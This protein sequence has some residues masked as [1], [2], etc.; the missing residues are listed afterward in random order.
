MRKIFKRN[1]GE[2]GEHKLGCLQVKK[3]P[4]L[5]LIYFVCVQY[6]HMYMFQGIH[7]SCAFLCANAHIHMCT[8][9]WRSEVNVLSLAT[10]YCETGTL[11]GP[12][13][14]W[15][16]ALT[17]KLQGPFSLLPSARIIGMCS[18]ALLFM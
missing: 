18:H 17:S 15:F 14:H 13:V 1:N 11:I 5:K 7:V 2:E 16:N 10:L 4:I 12:R 9:M 6:V 3:V 8:C